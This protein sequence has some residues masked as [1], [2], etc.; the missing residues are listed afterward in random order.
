[1]H[2]PK[3]TVSFLVARAKNSVQLLRHNN[4]SRSLLFY[5]QPS[6]SSFSSNAQ[7]SYDHDDQREGDPGEQRRTREIK[8]GV[9]G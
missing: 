1:M 6:L 9:G 3:S 2:Y 5:F 4:N 7:L 8:L